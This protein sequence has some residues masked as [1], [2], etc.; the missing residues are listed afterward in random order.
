M[1]IFLLCMTNAMLAGY[2]AVKLGAL[3]VAFLHNLLGL[4]QEH[5]LI[6][7]ICGSVNMKV[8]VASMTEGANAN[9]VLFADLMHVLQE[10]SNLVY[11]NNHVHFIEMFGVGLNYRKE[12]ATGSPYGTLVVGVGKNQ[13]VECAKLGADFCQR[14]C[15]LE[16][17]VLV[18]AIKGY[19]DIR[20]NFMAIYIS[21][22]LYTSDA[23][24]EL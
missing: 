4:L 24:D 16:D 22:L 1:Q 18:V 15:T 2:L 8:A 6:Y 11:G 19:Q 23:A 10:F 20:T 21:C 17:F 13:R 5:V 9:A 12:C 3:F 14:F 7:T